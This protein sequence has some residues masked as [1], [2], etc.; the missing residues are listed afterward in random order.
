[1]ESDAV[2][3]PYR[4]TV[5]TTNDFV[6]KKSIANT[7]KIYKQEDPYKPRGLWYQIKDSLF[8]WGE[9]NWGKHIYEV[10]IDTKCI[11]KISNFK[12]LEEFHNKYGEVF[13]K[14][15][16]LETINWKKVTKEY[17]GIE[18]I[19]YNKIIHSLTKKN[20]FGKYSWF[21]LFDFNSGCIWEVDAVKKV[22]YWGEI[23][24][25]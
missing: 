6:F 16:G 13:S 7:K 22:E 17:C 23:T 20:S 8:K 10:K 3:L 18:I 21:Y 11:C 12:Q 14:K 19:N 5:K 2:K 25:E 24:D 1:M 15:H 9:I 4:N